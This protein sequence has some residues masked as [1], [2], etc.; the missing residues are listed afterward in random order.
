MAKFQFKILNSEVANASTTFVSDGSG[1]SLGGII[2]ADRGMGRKIKN[3]ILVAKFGDGYE[4]RVG[5]GINLKEDSFSLSFNNRTSTEINKMAAFFDKK[6]G[7]SF[8]FSVTD[9]PDPAT[10][11][12]VDTDLKVVCDEYSIDYLRENIHS[13]STTFR[14]VYEP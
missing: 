2:T 13:L 7:E 1:A 3:R 12:T 8:T 9:V 5:D 10:G 4:Q 6:A 11:N 14:R